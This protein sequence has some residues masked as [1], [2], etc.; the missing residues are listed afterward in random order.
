MQTLLFLSQR[1]S[2]RSLLADAVCAVYDQC[3]PT[4]NSS[5]EA[6]SVQLPNTDCSHIC[7]FL[8]LPRP[9]K[10]GDLAKVQSSQHAEVWHPNL[11]DIP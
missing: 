5:L 1:D 9:N 3:M 2:C 11:L 4:M 7:D 8:H 10:A 6:A